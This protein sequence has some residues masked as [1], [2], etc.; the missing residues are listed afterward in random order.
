MHQEIRFRT[1][2]PYGAPESIC[3]P[4]VYSAPEDV[5]SSLSLL[6]LT[7]EYF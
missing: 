1:A 2:I 4:F 7:S 3:L 6:F 5:T